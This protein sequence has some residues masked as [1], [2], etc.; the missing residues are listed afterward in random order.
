MKRIVLLEEHYHRGEYIIGLRFSFDK[1]L[2]DLCKKNDL[3]W[4][5][6]HR[7]W[8]IKNSPGN[9]ENIKSMLAENYSIDESAL[10]ASYQARKI[11]R[12]RNT[13]QKERLIDDL[14]LT[15]IEELKKFK[16]YLRAKNYAT[17]TIYNYSA[18][19]KVYFSFFYDANPRELT[20]SSYVLFCNDYFAFGSYSKAYQRMLVCALR[21]YYKKIVRQTWDIEEVVYPRKERH[22]PVVLSRKEVYSIIRSTPNLKAECI[23]SLLYSCGLRVGEALNLKW[24]DFDRERQL[25]WVRQAKGFKDRSVPLSP[26]MITLLEEYFH[27]YRPPEYVFEGQ[28]GGRYSSSS[29]NQ[30]IRSVCL[31]LKITKRVT[32]HTFRHSFATHLMESGTNLR[33][34]QTLLGHKSSKTTEI[35]THVSEFQPNSFRNPF[36]DLFT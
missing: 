36:D 4:S 29:V 13:L 11:Q 28:Y 21:L 5:Y 26:K 12:V 14:N 25:I 2:M 22:L 17:N 9:Y 3:R 20:A 33:I 8:Y 30:I 31:K 7:C 1:T 10:R 6:T 15:A 19:L 34:I 18:A 32:A 24:T 16:Q 35:Y 27:R 23:L